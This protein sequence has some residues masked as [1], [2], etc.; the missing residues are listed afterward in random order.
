MSRVDF[1]NNNVALSNLRNGHVTL[2]NLRI[3]MSHVTIFTNPCLMSL[4]PKKAHIAVSN[5]GV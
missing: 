3:A 4:S 1:K 2:S 5:L